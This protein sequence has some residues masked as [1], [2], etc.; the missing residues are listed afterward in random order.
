MSRSLGESREEGDAGDGQH[1]ADDLLGG[2]SLLEEGETDEREQKDRRDTV[3]RTNLREL[4]RPHRPDPPEGG[5]SEER[6]A[7]DEPSVRE[8]ARF[9]ACELQEVVAQHANA[10]E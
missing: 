7:D 1:D 6:G 5:Q 9:L 2:E 4:H 10:A 3:D 8:H